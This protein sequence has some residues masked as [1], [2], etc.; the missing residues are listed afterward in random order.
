MDYYVIRS[1]S[2]Q[3]F[4]AWH[5]KRRS[6]GQVMSGFDTYAEAIAERDHLQRTDGSLSPL[7]VIPNPARQR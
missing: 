6:D 5:V 3:R 4:G 7:V 2:S 1:E